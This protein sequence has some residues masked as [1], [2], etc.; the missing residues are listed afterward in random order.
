MKTPSA[1]P[2]HVLVFDSGLGGITIYDAIRKQFPSVSLVYC[3]DNEGF[4]Y[5][6][7]RET[8]LIDRVSNVLVAL[9]TTFQPDIIVIAC[10]TA[11]T[12]AL[13][14]VRKRLKQAVVGVV[15]AIK[16]AAKITRAQHIGLLATPGTVQ[17]AYTQSLIAQFAPH[18]QWLLVG[19]S[20]L[21]QLA[22]QKMYGQT[23]S[24]EAISAA[25][26][27]FAQHPV[28][29][30]DTIVLGCT[31]FPLLKAELQHALPHIKHWIDSSDAIANR[32]GFWLREL[33]FQEN[34]SPTMPSRH[35]LVLTQKL[36]NE[37]S[38]QNLMK[39]HHLA[40]LTYLPIPHKKPPP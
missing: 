20:D 35:I 37:H 23:P 28:E 14:H 12:V 27:P 34:I 16:P 1:S 18:F 2:P 17:R 26:A 7:K 30:L 9:D 15:P 5:G 11:S 38:L 36:K 31:H 21:V 40:Q 22:E 25:V 33:G 3:S 10:N 24:P 8:E 6:N 32:V 39:E 19:S 4:P 13:P 29:E